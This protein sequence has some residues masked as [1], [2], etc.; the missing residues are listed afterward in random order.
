MSK[1]M[2]RALDQRVPGSDSE[3]RGEDAQRK[4]GGFVRGRHERIRERE[5]VI[6]KGQREGENKRE[7]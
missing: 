5:R 2:S 3:K 7:R 4:E 6:C 1:V